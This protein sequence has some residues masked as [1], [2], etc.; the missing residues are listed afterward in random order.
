MPISDEKSTFMIVNFPHNPVEP[1]Q[2][3][4]LTES[5]PL[6]NSYQIKYFGTIIDFNLSWQKH[7]EKIVK[8][9]K[10]GL[11]ML[12]S[13][14]NTKWG[15]HPKTAL[16]FY[17]SIIRPK[18]V[19]Y[20]FIYHNAES[21]LLRKLDV[22]QNSAIR[23]C[24]GVIRTTPINVLHSIAGLPTLEIRRKFIAKK[25]IAKANAYINNMF[26]PKFTLIKEK[27]LKNCLDK[28][29]L[30]KPIYFFISG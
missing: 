26:M 3:S 19:W 24:L 23:T 28:N 14:A 30:K 15:V 27:F 1:G 25:M 5:T 13:I 2:Y 11:N 9:C 17:K 8:S 16:L 22:I 6:K 4:V 29:M 7:I 18:I 20:F 21:R 12:N 10:I